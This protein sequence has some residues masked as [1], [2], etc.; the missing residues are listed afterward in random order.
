[1]SV[2][3][4]KGS[5]KLEGWGETLSKRDLVEIICQLEEELDTHPLSLVGDTSKIKE[6]ANYLIHDFSL[7]DHVYTVRDRVCEDFP[8]YEG[9]SWDHSTVNRFT[10]IWKMLKEIADPVGGE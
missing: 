1:M 3:Y 10:E 4:E 6:I 5:A 8:E 9:N 2:V 7:E